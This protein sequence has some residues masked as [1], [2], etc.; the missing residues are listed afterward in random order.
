MELQVE[1]RGKLLAPPKG[2]VADK[3]G[4]YYC[5]PRDFV[6][7]RWDTR[8]PLVAESHQVLLQSAELL[9]KVHQL[10]FDL[11]KQLWALTDKTNETQCVRIRRPIPDYLW[12]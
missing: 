6:C 1:K 3:Q 2:M 8:L 12:I 9:P 5:V 11:Q 7:L 10:F 4:L